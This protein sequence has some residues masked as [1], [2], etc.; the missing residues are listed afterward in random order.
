MINEQRYNLPKQVAPSKIPWALKESRW[1]MKMTI[2]RKSRRKRGNRM[3][4]AESGQSYHI[5]NG[6]KY[7]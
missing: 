3:S 4:K 1:D 6:K 5:V 2:Y 7:D